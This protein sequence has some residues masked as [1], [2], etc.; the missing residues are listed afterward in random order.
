MQA[1]STSTV[2]AR[3]GLG[4]VIFAG[5]SGTARHHGASTSKAT[6]CRSMTSNR[7]PMR[8]LH[9]GLADR[10]LPGA[11][12][13]RHDRAGATG[14]RLSPSLPAPLRRDGLGASATQHAHL[15]RT[16]RKEVRCALYHKPWTIKGSAPSR[17]FQYLI[18]FQLP[19]TSSSSRR[20]RNL[21]AQAMPSM[22]T[23]RLGGGQF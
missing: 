9:P 6:S 5:R 14:Q 13:R 20:S 1:E 2:S 17:S 22:V 4:R 21:R 12:A 3:Q 23:V 15:Q 16:P 19:T 18:C 10:S 11:R 8:T 7:S